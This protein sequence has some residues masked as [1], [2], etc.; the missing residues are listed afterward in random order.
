MRPP[1]SHAARIVVKWVPWTSFQVGTCASDGQQM[2]V[3][4][5]LLPSRPRTLCANGPHTHTHVKAKEN[6]DAPISA[7]WSFSPAASCSSWDIRCANSF[8]VSVESMGF[9]ALPPFLP[10]MAATGGAGGGLGSWGRWVPLGGRASW[11]W[12]AVVEPLGRVAEV[13]DDIFWGGGGAWSYRRAGSW[14]WAGDKP[15]GDGN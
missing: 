7:S 2:R 1:K 14:P 13:A 6:K 8:E 10:G 12:W 4:A 9:L 15:E 3:G 5:A 11:S